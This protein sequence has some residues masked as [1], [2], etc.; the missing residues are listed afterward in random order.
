MTI[1]TNARR[2]ALT[3]A[4]ATTILTGAA[5][6]SGSAFA[7]QAPAAHHDATPNGYSPVET[8]TSLVGSV[9]LNPGLRKRTHAE[10]VV[11]NGTLDGCNAYGQAQ[12]G[13][14]TFTAILA[15]NASTK[16]GQ[17]TGTFTA[18][19]PA[20]AGLNPSNGTIGIS[21]TARGSYT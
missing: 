18:N 12:A 19:W 8:C 21:T 4:A 5:A 16:T 15:G 13:Q 9:H 3:V 7:A 14:G 6:M 17:L 11:I 1:T 10:S 2:I 20:S